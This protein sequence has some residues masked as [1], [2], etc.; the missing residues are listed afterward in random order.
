MEKIVVI[1]KE[2]AAEMAREHRRAA[3]FH[4]TLANGWTRKVH[5]PKAMKLRE[6]AARRDLRERDW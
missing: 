3:A 5:R 6:K 4:D 1:T 2:E